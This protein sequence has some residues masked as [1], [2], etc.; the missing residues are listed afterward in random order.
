VIWEYLVE[1][2]QRASTNTRY[3]KTAENKQVEFWSPEDERMFL[4]HGYHPSLWDDCALP[5]DILVGLERRSGK[6]RMK[7]LKPADTLPYWCDVPDAQW[8]KCS[9]LKPGM[10]VFTPKGVLHHLIRLD[11]KQYRDDVVFWTVQ[12][13]ASGKIQP[14]TRAAYYVDYQYLTVQEVLMPLGG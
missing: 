12:V 7:Y 13:E 6:W 11:D 4:Q 14:E 2:W 9:D 3:G 10:L 8:V 5:H 1:F